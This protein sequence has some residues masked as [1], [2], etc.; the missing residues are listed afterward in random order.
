MTQQLL[1]YHTS[2]LSPAALLFFFFPC[3][4]FLKILIHC[5]FSPSCLSHSLPII[6]LL[7]TTSDNLFSTFFLIQALQ[8]R[9]LNIVCILYLYCDLQS[10]VHPHP[11][12]LSFFLSLIL[13]DPISLHLSLQ[14]WQRKISPPI[15]SSVPRLHWTRAAVWRE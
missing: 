13:F 10:H 11:I 1:L 5:S 3:S 15:L 14:L 2:S 7:F 12:S 9:S 6:Y 8:C 4:T